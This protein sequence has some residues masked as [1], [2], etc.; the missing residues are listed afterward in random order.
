MLSPSTRLCLFAGDL[1]TLTLAQPEH[2]L[3]F[4]LGAAAGTWQGGSRV[5]DVTALAGDR[6]GV[7]AAGQAAS[8]RFAASM[9]ATAPQVTVTRR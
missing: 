4:G 1:A 3:H 8:A 7:P 9:I 6:I 5:V 2:T